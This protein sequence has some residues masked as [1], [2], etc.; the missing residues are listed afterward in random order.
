LSNMHHTASLSRAATSSRSA[1]RSASPLIE[2]VRGG[3]ASMSVANQS[4]PI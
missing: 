3:A 1:S 2:M 4:V